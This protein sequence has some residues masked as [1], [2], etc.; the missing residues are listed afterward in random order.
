LRGPTQLKGRVAFWNYEL[1]PAQ[2]N[3]W[4]RE[5]GIESND[6]A[7]VLA[8]RGHMLPLTTHVGE[9]FAVRWLEER[10]VEFW[11]VD[12]FARAMTD[13]GLDENSNSDIDVLTHALDVIKQRAGVKNLLLSAHTGRMPQEEGKEHSR[14]G[15][16]LDDWADNR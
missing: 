6:R 2:F 7:A 12:T 4:L 5:I 11:I 10:E 3:V 9:D 14:G 8:L 15:T 1:S 16:R 13:C